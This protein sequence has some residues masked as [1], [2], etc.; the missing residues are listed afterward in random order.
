MT[1]S[2]NSPSVQKNVLF[3][4]RA[5]RFL[6]CLSW[7]LSE[8]K[9]QSTGEKPKQKEAKRQLGFSPENNVFL[10]LQCTMFSAPTLE[11][12]SARTVRALWTR[13]LVASLGVYSFVQATFFSSGS[14]AA[15]S[16]PLLL[17]LASR[18]VYF[19]SRRLFANNDLV[20]CGDSPRFHPKN[21]SARW[22]SQRSL[23]RCCYGN[24]SDG[25]MR[26]PS[27]S[28]TRFEWDWPAV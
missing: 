24:R 17:L 19:S 5:S 13:D 11:S 15:R 21:A 16:G 10:P 28:G 18:V 12:C 2:S 14:A 25:S 27:L 23:R 7:F 9:R 3:F 22:F 1:H 4:K 8:N 26:R 6:D 20:S